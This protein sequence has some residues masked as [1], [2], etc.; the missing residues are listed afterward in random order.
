[1][2][3]FVIGTRGGEARDAADIQQKTNRKKC[4][5]I[6]GQPPTKL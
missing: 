2:N 4:F 6:V 3:S 5:Q 1:M